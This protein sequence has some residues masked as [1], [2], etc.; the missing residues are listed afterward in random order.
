[1]RGSW[2]G[3]SAFG[4]PLA[5]W[6]CGQAPTTHASRVEVATARAHAAATAAQPPASTQWKTLATPQPTASSAPVPTPELRAATHKLAPPPQP[7][8]DTATTAGARE[9][10]NDRDAWR[11]VLA[12]VPEL[13]RHAASF[14]PF[15]AKA[16]EEALKKGKRSRAN[17]IAWSIANGPLTWSP[18]PDRELWVAAGSVGRRALVAVLS[19]QRDGSIRHEVSLLIDDQDAQVALA[20]SLEHPDELLWST[21]Y[22]CPGE[23][24]SIRLGDDGRARFVYR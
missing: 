4:L 17:V 9:L 1:M 12:H 14:E 7:A 6:A 21:C 18:T 10:G 3:A 16:A 23:G 22:G 8:T 11:T 5:L 2:V 15:G 19:P 13:S 20:S 24:G